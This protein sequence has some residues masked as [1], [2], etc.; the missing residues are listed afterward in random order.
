M[1]QKVNT[2]LVDDLDGSEAAETVEF[3]LAGVDYSIDLSEANAN[4]LR[5]ILAVYV[6]NGRRTGGRAK[7]STTGKASSGATADREQN[8][9]IRSWAKE[10][11]Y[12]LADRGR[13]PG[14]VVEAY[15]AQ[16]G[17]GGLAAVG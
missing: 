11:G 17:R 13:I 6:E 10:N 15:H 16:A 2:Y 4:E 1:A 5:D 8:Q 9:A 12:E 7:R 3:G 14:H